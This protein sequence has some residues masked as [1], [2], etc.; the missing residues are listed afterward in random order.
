MVLRKLFFS[1]FFCFL[2]LC[3]L[4][5]EKWVG[6]AATYQK[7]I[8]V[9]TVSGVVFNEN[10]YFAACNGFKIGTSVKVRNIK[11][12]KEIVVVINDRIEGNVD[13]F[14]LL[15]PM[16]A[17]DLDIEW[18]TAI[19]VVE[20]SFYDIDS[21]ERL[22]IAGLLPEDKVDPELLRRFPDI[23]FSID[24]KMESS[25]KK[26]IE[27]KE[28][29]IVEVK[30][31]AAD[32]AIKDLYP[33]PER[34]KKVVQ[35]EKDFKVETKE[36]TS[37]SSKI[38]AEKDKIEGPEKEKSKVV[39]AE[40]IIIPEKINQI[41]EK[42]KISDLPLEKKEDK[43]VKLKEDLKEEKAEIEV[44]EWDKSLI[45]GKSY[46]RF[47]AAFEREEAERRILLFKNIFKNLIW[48]KSDSRYILLIGPLERKDIDVELDK[49]RAFGF[50]D[51]Y[52][53]SGH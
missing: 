20:A 33:M 38:V 43:K 23:K 32:I 2:S 36:F 7:R 9:K 53:V 27:K 52:V 31:E 50:K 46:I 42:E 10:S 13:Y 29:P 17:R 34:E 25:E 48:I 24:N 16:A 11:N 51:A 39:L 41:V 4:F 28:E 12:D 26:V 22:D 5:S 35:L 40:D 30:K 3:L 47:S 14:I 6:K 15:T 21:T 49:V 8:G 1:C 44:I 45:K 18:Q 37:S 19:V